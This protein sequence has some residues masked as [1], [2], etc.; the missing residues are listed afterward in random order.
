MNLIVFRAVGALGEHVVLAVVAVAHF[1]QADRA[2]HV[3]QFAVAIGGAGQAV[4][5]M[6]GDIKLHHAA[7]D[8]REPRILRRHLDA[9]RDGRRA[10]GRRTLA[11]LDLAQAKAAR[12][13]RVEA[14]GGAE[15]RDL[16]AELHRG[17]HDR[18]ALGNRDLAAIDLERDVASSLREFRAFWCRSPSL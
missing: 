5:R 9:R 14:I 2:R 17:V 8:F 1:A 3:L 15:L 11:A 6:V 18:R 10:R 4:E 7:A 13:E 12:A 16:D